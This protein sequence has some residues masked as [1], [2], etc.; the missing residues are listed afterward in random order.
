M[1]IFRNGL[2]TGLV[3][4]LGIG[5][6]FFFIINLAL[7]RTLLDGLVGALAVA[8]VDFFY[9]TLA[10]FGIG[11]LLEHPRV[12]RTFGIISS[13]VLIIF[14]FII[15]N[16]VRGGLAATETHAAS[17]SLF[18]SFSSVF[19]LTISS[20]M[21]IVWFTSLFTTIAVEYNYTK[22][23]LFLFGFGT[24]CATLLFMSASV[25]L[26]T[27]IKG[28][29]PIPLIQTLNLVVGLLLIGYGGFRVAK[30]TIYSSSNNAMLEIAVLWLV[31]NEKEL[32]LTKRSLTRTLH[33]GEWGPTVTG[34]AKSGEAPA[35]TLER[36]VEEELGLQPT[37]YEPQ[38]LFT[39]DFNHPDGRVRRFSIYV[40]LVG[41][42]IADKFTIDANEVADFRWLPM[43]RVRE[44]LI[45][46]APEFTIVPSAKEVW[47][48]TFAMIEHTFL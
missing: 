5:P 40:A 15:I 32:L 2:A 9:I 47:P 26:F 27:F 11:K 46:S 29:V 34:T 6:V 10:I 1:N 21:T 45:A 20:P 8:I 16:G 37:D 44:L 25:I 28:T 3:L 18:S 12:K 7:Q 41:K 22:K 19:F 13:F 23:Q 33:P 31:T 48:E 30:N 4:Q 24:G 39:R 14:G 38:F 17:T 43:R 36:E 42:N 35:Q